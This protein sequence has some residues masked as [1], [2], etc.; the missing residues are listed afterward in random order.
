MNAPKLGKKKKDPNR[1]LEWTS[2]YISY[3]SQIINE[4]NT[5]RLRAA[6]LLCMLCAMEPTK[7][8]G[9]IENAKSLLTDTNWLLNA[10]ISRK[11]AKQMLEDSPYWHYEDDTL[12]IDCHAANAVNSTIRKRHNRPQKK[13]EQPIMADTVAEYAEVTPNF[14]TA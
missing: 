11:C 12:I 1:P 6:I 8:P 13:S 2:L 4:K 3:R 14:Y 7:Y 10:G 5:E 9:Y